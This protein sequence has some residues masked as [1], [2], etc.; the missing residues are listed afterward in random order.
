MRCTNQKSF[1]FN[2]HSLEVPYMYVVFQFWDKGSTSVAL[3]D[4][5]ES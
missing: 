4:L 3:K 5:E 2:L 1:S